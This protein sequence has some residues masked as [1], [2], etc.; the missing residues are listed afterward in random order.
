MNGSFSS[1]KGISEF[2][3]AGPLSQDVGK[4]TAI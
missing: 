2:L 1:E 4:C 3:T